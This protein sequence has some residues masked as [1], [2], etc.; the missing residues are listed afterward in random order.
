M[1][2]KNKR[3]FLLLG[4]LGVL[5]LLLSSLA[6]ARFMPTTA[7]PRSTPADSHNLTPI[8]SNQWYSNIYAQFPT[9]PLY[10]L[11]AAFQL[12][13]Q[14]VGVSLPDVSKSAKTI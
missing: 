9:E 8:A 4:L 10:T 12:S 5:F 7:H 6:S 2:K 3:L 14:G 1:K 13:P 11:P